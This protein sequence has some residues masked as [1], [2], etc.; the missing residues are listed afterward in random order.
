MGQERIMLIQ[1]AGGN[2]F[3]IQLPSLND[4]ER[5]KIIKKFY[6]KKPIKVKFLGQFV[7]CYI[8]TVM[9]KKVE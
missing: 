8:S 2:E 9:I 4:L 5:A 1:C 6:D 7:E 3:E